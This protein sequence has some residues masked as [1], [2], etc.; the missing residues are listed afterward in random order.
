MNLKIATT[1]LALTCIACNGEQGEKN[2]PA[3]QQAAQ[4]TVQEAAPVEVAPAE[5][6]VETPAPEVTAEPAPVEEVSLPDTTYPSANVLEFVV[7]VVDKNTSGKIT[8]FEDVYANAPGIFTFR[9]GLK[10]N[11]P[12]EGKVTGTPSKISV[13]WE[14]KTAF[15]SEPTKL[16]TWGGGSGWTGQPVYVNWPDSIYEKFKNEA[17]GLTSNFSKEEIMV[18]S[19]SSNVYFIDFATGKASRKE[20]DVSNPIKGSISLDPSLNGNLY[21][22]QGVPKTDEV[23]FGAGVINLYKNKITHFFNRDKNAWRGWGAY[24]SSPVVVGDFLIRP[25]ENGTVYK[26]S[27][28]QGSLSLHSSMKYRVKKKKA[29]GIE[30]SIAVYRNYGYFGDNN[31]NIVCI[32]LDTMKPVWY[33]DNHDDT[34]GSIVINEEDGVP[35]IYTAS[36]MDKQGDKGISYFVKLNGLNGEKVWEK[37]FKCNKA[38]I[39]GK[40]FD[41]GMYSTPLV[42]RGDCDSLLIVPMSIH[43]PIFS[44]NLVALNRYTGKVVYEVPLEH[45]AWSSPVGFYNEDNKLFVVLGD[46]AGNMYIFEGATGKRLFM[47]KIGDNFESSPAVAGNSLVVGSRGKVIFKM[48]VE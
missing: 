4:G 35:Y 6:A 8:S 15:D 9:G 25:G 48:N 7:D 23:P 39:A 11:T 46:C 38:K 16:G 13:A 42:G 2:Q 17:V 47:K 29:P 44:G 19:L 27:R 3:K 18:G 36:E 37:Q 14:F 43:K 5:A 24:D 40:S 45:Y 22:G 32:N 21:F 10:R 1:L 33:Y 20:V 26:F 34:D 41:G 30:S 28:K 12:H 31:G